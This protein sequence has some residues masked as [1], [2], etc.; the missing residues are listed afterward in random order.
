MSGTT[1]PPSATF[2]TAVLSDAEKADVRRFCGYPTYGGASN[3]G[4]QNWR[5]YEQF[6]LL[7]FRMNNLAAAEY[8]NVRYRLSL[9]YPIETAIAAAYTTLNVDQAAAFKRNANEIAAR[10]GH[11]AN[12]CRKLCQ[13]V[14]VVPGPNLSVSGGQMAVVV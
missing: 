9:L 11:F 14:G 12:E 2:S 1:T 10:E 5:F 6:G 13:V 8:Q 3:A 7:E 4:F